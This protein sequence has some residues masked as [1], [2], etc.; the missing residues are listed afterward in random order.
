MMGNCKDCKYWNGSPA[1]DDRGVGMY[2]AEEIKEHPGMGVCSEI[3]GDEGKLTH[4]YAIYA[5]GGT[6]SFTSPDF[7]CVLFEAKGSS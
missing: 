3:L 5:D 6:Y 2:G 4:I 1:P 7:G